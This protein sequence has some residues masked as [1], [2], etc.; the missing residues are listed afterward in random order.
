MARE[1]TEAVYAQLRNATELV[2]LTAKQIAESTGCSWTYVGSV[3]RGLRNCS[4]VLYVGAGIPQ[5]MPDKSIT[6]KY[7][8]ITNAYALNDLRVRTGE[9]LT[10]LKEELGSTVIADKRTG[11]VV[12]GRERL[13]T[14]VEELKGGYYKGG[15]ST[16]YNTNPRDAKT[17]AQLNANSLTPL[18]RN[19]FGTC[20]CGGTYIYYRNGAV[21]CKSQVHGGFKLVAVFKPKN[22]VKPSGAKPIK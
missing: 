1:A 7:S 2:F 10:I 8:D 19:P 17:I 22:S 14:V 20:P 11:E 12:I 13:E 21:G 3:L 4:E 18:N 9:W 15:K 16:P 5:R 6:W